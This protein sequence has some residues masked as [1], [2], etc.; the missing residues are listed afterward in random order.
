MLTWEPVCLG[1]GSKYG[2]G[3]QAM[4]SGGGSVKHPIQST[5]RF[6][7]SGWL[8]EYMLMYRTLRF[9]REA[10]A[11]P[12]AICYP[13]FTSLEDW[14][15]LLFMGCVK[16]I[17]LDCNT[18]TLTFFHISSRLIDRRTESKAFKAAFNEKENLS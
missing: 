13:C 10:L 14:A 15:V 2:L 1:F 6:I 9:W 8:K 16:I 5:W 4:N 11:I 3:D 7:D 17:A 12:T 18:V